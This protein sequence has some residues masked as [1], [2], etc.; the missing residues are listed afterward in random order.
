[1]WLLCAAKGCK[2][3]FGLRRCG[4][5]TAGDGSEEQEIYRRETLSPKPQ[6]D[7]DPIWFVLADRFPITPGERIISLRSTNK[8]RQAD[9]FILSTFSAVMLFLFN[10]YKPIL[11]LTHRIVLI[12]A[13][14]CT[15]S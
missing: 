13:Y 7:V 3:D 15:P 10:F 5:S 2:V 8:C 14:T 6:D 12:L 11:L 1:M 9:R 4:L